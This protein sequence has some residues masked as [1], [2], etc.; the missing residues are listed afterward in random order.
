MVS[1]FALAFIMFKKLIIFCLS[2]LVSCHEFAVLKWSPAFQVK[3]VKTVF[4]LCSTVSLLDKY[5]IMI[6]IT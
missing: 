2:P 5:C 4:Y 1:P 6:S 3:T